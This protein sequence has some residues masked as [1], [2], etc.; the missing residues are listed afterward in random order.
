[1]ITRRRAQSSPTFTAQNIHGS[2]Y[3]LLVLLIF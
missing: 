2:T 1:M 3:V